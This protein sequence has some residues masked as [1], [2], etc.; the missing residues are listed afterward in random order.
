MMTLHKA[1]IFHTSALWSWLFQASYA[2]LTG[3]ITSIE[4]PY[5]ITVKVGNP[6][7]A[8]I[9]VLRWNNIF[10]NAMQLPVV[11]TAQD[12]Q[13]AE[14]Q[15]ASHYV[16]RAGM[17]D[18]DLYT[19]E[20]GHNFSQTLDIRQYLQSIPSGPTGSRSKTI[21]L[22]LPTSFKGVSGIV[23]I[24]PKA[25]AS[26]NSQPPTLGDFAASGLADITLTAN[27]LQ[28]SMRFPLYQNLDPSFTAAEDGIQLDSN[29]KAQNATDMS[30]ALFDAS[31]YAR[32]VKLAANSRPDG[33]YT[34]FF[35]DLSRQNISS[36]AGAAA[37][38]IHGAGRHVDLYCSDNREVCG[39]PNILGYTFTPSYVG[40]A[41]IVLCPSARAL[42]RAPEPCSA[43][44]PGVQIDASSSHVLFHL[45]FTL[46]NV[47]NSVI[48][49][50]VYG[51]FACSQLVN[52]TSDP[53]KNAD[54]FAQLAIAQWAY[55]L[56]GAPYN[57]P[58]CVPAGGIL[59]GNQK[60]A[61]DSVNAVTP[62][63]VTAATDVA[64][65]RRLVSYDPRV[66]GRCTGAEMDILQI[67]GAN[68]R[69]LA[70]YALNEIN[71]QSNDLWT[72]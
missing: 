70:T 19:L 27:I 65:S 58:S 30:N 38:S 55:G 16:M 35:S 62:E 26:L 63:P 60:R 3:S 53:T 71:S 32:A 57:G 34:N 72:T 22:S 33:F 49:N 23:S 11:F 24:S 7:E 39:D 42:G 9:S 69:F 59:S 46:N 10:D 21:T 52:S 5:I 41:Y 36:I 13:G 50:S 40:N 67:A 48:S 37:R 64:V 15:M 56:G 66:I 2:Q 25:A 14:V 20:P 54:S 6:T 51:S 17:S 45:L 47:V 29:C 18:S 43:L 31:L 8:T 44:Q 61:A 68:A 4:N 12:D 28:L 1:R